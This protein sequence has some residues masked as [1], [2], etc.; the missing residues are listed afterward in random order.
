MFCRKEYQNMS[1]LWP[2]EENKK[3]DWQTKKNHIGIL[4]QIFSE[5][6]KHCAELSKLKT[7]A[8]EKQT[9]RQRQSE[10]PSMSTSSTVYV[11]HPFSCQ[12]KERLEI[13]QNTKTQFLFNPTKL[14][15]QNNCHVKH[16]QSTLVVPQARRRTNKGLPG[17]L[18]RQSLLI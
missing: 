7:R 1:S 15:R 10:H 4:G 17:T 8:K 5:A 18:Y 12:E 14:N 9:D 6:S 11:G 2:Q 13:G 3:R 16:N